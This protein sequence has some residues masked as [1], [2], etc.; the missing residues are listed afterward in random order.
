MAAVM[1]GGIEVAGSAVDGASAV[2][3]PDAMAFVGGLARRFTPQVR[4]LL[5]SEAGD[6]GPLR[7]G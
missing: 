4:E 3:C 2:L 7:R 1:P 6:A 5:M